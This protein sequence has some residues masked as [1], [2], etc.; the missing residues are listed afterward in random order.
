MAKGNPL[1]RKSLSMFVRE[2]RQH[3]ILH[4]NA[5]ADARV[6]NNIRD[7]SYHDGFKV[8]LW[9]TANDLVKEYGL[10]EIE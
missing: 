2:L 6:R 1:S 3:V 7:E 4:Q 9:Q 10:E 5:C 8:G